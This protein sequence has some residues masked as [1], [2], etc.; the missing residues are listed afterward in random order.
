MIRMLPLISKK[1]FMVFEE[2]KEEKK[3]HEIEMAMAELEQAIKN[4]HMIMKKVKEH[5]HTELE[6]WVQSKIT[7]SADYLNSVAGWLD[8]H[9]GLDDKIGT[10]DDNI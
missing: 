3:D 10:D 9:D 5:G 6:A 8:S 7:K 4:A 1:A 2:E